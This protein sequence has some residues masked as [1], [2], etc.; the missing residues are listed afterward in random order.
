VPDFIVGAPGFDNGPKKQHAGQVTIYSGAT[1][2]SLK[3]IVGKKAAGNFG[4]SV[5]GAGDVNGD[6]VR[7]VV[8]GAIGASFGEKRTAAGQVSIFSGK[9]F[10]SLGSLRGTVANEFLGSSVAGAG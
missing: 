2:A 4:W 3:T 5:A 1:R 7:D 8:V 6:G 9:K 10:K